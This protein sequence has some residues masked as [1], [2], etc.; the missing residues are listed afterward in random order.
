MRAHVGARWLNAL[1]Q[2][3]NQQRGRLR[4]SYVV[5][6]VEA[7]NNRPSQLKPGLQSFDVIYD[8]QNCSLR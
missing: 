5:N 4:C 8:E 6:Q 2:R 7:G 3:I 1:P